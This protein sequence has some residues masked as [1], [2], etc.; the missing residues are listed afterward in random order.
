[1]R[2][3]EVPDNCIVL[4]NAK[5]TAPGMWFEKDGVVIVSLPGVPH[6]MMAI[7]EEGVL[8]RLHHHHSSEKIIHRHIMTAG[9]GE[10]FLAERIADIEASLP[11]Y[12]RLAYLPANWILKLRLTA[13]GTDEA[14]LIAET[15]KYLQLIK[16]RIPEYFITLKD[17]PF[18]RILQKQFTQQHKTLALAESCTGGYIGHTLTQVDGSS[19]YF[20][21]S[22][23]SYDAS[24]KS[25]VLNIP[26]Q[27]ILTEGEVSEAIARQMAE[28]V[29]HLLHTDIGFGIT[30]WL[31]TGVPDAGTVWMAVTNGA[32]TFAKKYYFPY[33]RI[34]NK[35]IALQMAL[36]TIW[37]FINEKNI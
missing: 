33:D 2:Q 9:L 10:S 16:E 1:M 31:S 27:D 25:I 34:R 19:R 4:Q 15:E 24:V 18:E 11:P 26:E 35:E 37:K 22:I 28:R 5:G 8:P 3:A 20:M 13:R 29:R 12:I 23:V 36:L 32:K 14:Q 17:E 6:E 30:G 7:M 21:G